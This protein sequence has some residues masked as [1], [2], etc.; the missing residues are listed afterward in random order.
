MLQMNSPVPAPAIVEPVPQAGAVV[1]EELAAVKRKVL[2]RDPEYRYFEQ[3]SSL[4]K[5]NGLVNCLIS[6]EGESHDPDTAFDRLRWGGQYVGV[7]SRKSE[8]ADLPQKFADVGFL[9]EQEPAYVRTEWGLPL[10]SPKAHFF[11]ARKFTLIRP[12]EFSDRFT[13]QVQLERRENAHAEGPPGTEHWVVRKEVPTYDRILTRLRAKAPELPITTLERRAKKFSDQIFPLFLTREA[14]MLKIIE[15]DCPKEYR[16]HFPRV[17]DLEKDE[18][19]Y[20]QRMWTTWLRNGGRALSQ[21]EFAR[22]AAELVHIL[23]DRIGIIHLDLRMD[24]LVITEHGVGFVDFGSAVRVNENIHGN[25]VL[26]T[27]F[28]ELMRT[29]QIQR[30]LDRM[31]TA[32]SVTSRIIREA[33]QRVDKAVD[34]FYLAVQISQPTA[35]PDIRELIKY[36]KFSPE[37]VGLAG[38]TEA[39]LRPPNP[40]QPRF[41]TARDV[42][43]EILRI[44]ADVKSGKYDQTAAAEATKPRVWIWK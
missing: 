14:A 28:G 25:A 21:L 22:Q 6:T 4:A 26:S 41:K 32:G 27:L 9:I 19:G 13:Y 20:V 10:I 33:Y 39:I 44:E 34:L 24:N 18:N 2:D 31:S 8:I 11:V 43:D 7:S 36:E 42:R 1:T 23:H 16:H 5:R 17:I 29:S 35:N 30:M 37:A 3:T 12:R 40:N 38:L 15:R